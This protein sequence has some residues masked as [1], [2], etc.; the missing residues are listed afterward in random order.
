[1]ANKL[2]GAILAILGIF[3]IVFVYNFDAVLNRKTA[4]GTKAIICFV[5]GGIAVINGI[6][7]FKRKS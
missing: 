4:F 6:R 7:I 5:I 2:K 3:W 1:M